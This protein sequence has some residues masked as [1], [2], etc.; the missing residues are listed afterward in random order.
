MPSRLRLTLLL[1][2]PLLLIA[3]TSMVTQLAAEEPS[4]HAKEPQVLFEYETLNGEEYGYRIP[5]LVKTNSGA[6]L[7]V[8]ERRLGLHDH[9]ENDL[10]MRRSTDNGKTWS[11]IEL[12]AE[13][14]SDSLNDPCMIVL[15][16]GRILLRYIH[17]PHGVHA[18][19]TDHTVRALAG[20]D[21]PKNVRLF[22]MH[23]D[24]EGQSWSEPRDV[25]RAFRREGAISLGSPGV[26]IQLTTGE[27]AGRILFPNYEV[28][29]VGDADRYTRNSASYSDDDGETWHLSEP[30]AEPT[31]QGQGNEAQVVELATGELLL[32]SRDQDGGIYRKLSR[33]TD[34]GE[35]WSTH[36]FLTEFVTPHC[37][38]S[39]IRYQHDGEDLL[40]HC[41]PN[42]R[43]WRLHG[44]VFY[45]RDGGEHWLTAREIEPE[46][47]GYNVLCQLA[48]GR[49]GCLYETEDCLKIVF[50][51]FSLDDLF[52]K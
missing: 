48:N 49:I 45:S 18:R 12:I 40:L 22:L 51:D 28:F 2:M 34:G 42:S 31:E 7:A 23:S 20:Y 19:K 25:T 21:G 27:H 47:L 24:D 3:S 14:G 46:Y 4:S 10:V 16:S 29:P 11:S 38:A 36:T 6:L 26:G 44:T 13:A 17:F 15:D 9:S 43:R 35:T 8:A 37:M 41:G 50:T 52:I 30:I 39:L 5:S 1:G 33:S 32:S